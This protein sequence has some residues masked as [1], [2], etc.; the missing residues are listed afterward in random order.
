VSGTRVSIIFIISLSFSCWS[1]HNQK[2]FSSTSEYWLLEDSSASL[3]AEQAWRN[4]QT[5]QF[6]RQTSFSF[7]PGFTTSQYWLAVKYDTSPV[8][9]NKLEIGTSQI[10]LI[11]FFR[12]EN[13]RPVQQIVTGDHLP[14]HSR[15][16]QS[17]N[18]V[19]ELDKKHP[20][21]L[22]K[23]DK[24]NESLQLTF[25][26]KP[27]N[28]LHHFA[29]ESSMIVGI[30]SGL[31]LLMLIFGI[32]L[33]LITGEKV[34]LLYTLYVGGGWLYVIANLGYGYK[35]LWPNEPWFA[36]RARP[37][38]VL[39]TIG[40]SVFFI[41]YYAGKPA[42]KWLWITLKSLTIVSFGMAAIAIVPV[43]EIKQNIFGYY[44]Q[45]LLPVLVVIYLGGILTTLIQKIANKNRMALF[46]L[47][48]VIPIAV[49]STLQT[50]YYS[51]ALDFSGSYL[52]YY[53]QAT[54]YVME[55]VI[56]TFGLAYRFN[57][58]R[59]EKEQLL[60]SINQQQARYTKA[61]IT[62][63]ENERRQIA[64]Q[65]HD[66]AGSLLSAAKL[67]LSSVREKN[68]ITQ[69][70][71][72]Q[73]LMQA[74]DAVTSISTM[75]RN[76]SHAISPV[77]LDKV[78]FRQSTEKICNI[79]NSAGKLKV[80][81]EVLG[82]ENDQAELREKYSVLYG[83]LYELVNNISKHAQATHALIQLIEH[84]DSMVMIVEDNGVGLSAQDLQHSTQGLAGIQSKI[85]YLNGNV[86]FD[87]ATPSGLIVTI[88]IPKKNDDENYFSR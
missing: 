34:Y 15:P 78:G 1:C 50:V 33:W 60:I 12:I 9:H 53:G 45:A 2:Q 84:D 31:I 77:M 64:D 36:A 39:I 82:F 76:L 69:P 73:K 5:D 23:I 38:C 14:F 17:L 48:S 16:E 63:E 11:E 70:E 52:Q 62:T 51:G 8:E 65:L 7:N 41:K 88:E 57:T 49:F 83:I 59:K 19:F 54:G 71:A 46:Y 72:Q 29:L 75:L 20:Y 68:F 80:E 24:R 85:H 74:E 56:L 86:T 32:F 81:L 58:Y 18:Y 26:I 4:F 6:T 10:N 40:F 28:E 37:F 13:G 35:Y 25:V 21:Y 79:F 30:L 67:N 47:L 44:F 61:I 3:S 66:V 55:A 43:F 27:A 42:W 22:L 87:G